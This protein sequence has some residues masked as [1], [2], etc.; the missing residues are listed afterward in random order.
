MREI[1]TGWRRWRIE[2]RVSAVDER[3][4][5]SRMC[6]MAEARNESFACFAEKV[7]RIC[8]GSEHRER[9]RLTTS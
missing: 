4:Y 6:S 2:A 5:E 1:E 8:Q 7:A 9:R 3:D